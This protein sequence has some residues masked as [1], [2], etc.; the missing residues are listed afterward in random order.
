VRIVL[1]GPP[2][3]GK[4]T[5]ATRLAERYGL[6]HIATGDIL[7]WNVQ[8]GTELGKLAGKFM[9][10]GELVPDDVV[11]RM[12]SHAL[13]ASA[14]RWILDGFPRTIPQAEALEAELARAGQPITA[15]LFLSVNDELAVTRIAGRRTCAR[16]QQPYNVALSPPREPGV[17][18]ACGGELVQRPDDAEEVVRNRLAVYH[19]RTAPLLEFYRSRGLLRE[20]DAD[21]E[22]DVVTERAAEFLS[23]AAPAPSEPT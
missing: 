20:I 8:E 17:C 12:V 5:Q 11:V 1:L 13:E 4:G 15:V 2:G 9:A 14:D 16:C 22:E 21:A 23:E 7:R 3:A 6:Q 18:D 10:E 19:Q